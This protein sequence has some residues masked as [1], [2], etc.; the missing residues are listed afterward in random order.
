MTAAVSKEVWP[1]PLHRRSKP[2]RLAYHLTQAE[3]P[4]LHFSLTLVAAL[5][6]CGNRR[7]R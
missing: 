2:G 7:S 3:G 5:F 6:K 4:G 1:N